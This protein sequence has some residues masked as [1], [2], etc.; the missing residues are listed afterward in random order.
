MPFTNKNTWA[1]AAASKLRE[2]FTN[3]DFHFIDS[4]G[5][6]YEFLD[7]IYF[8]FLDERSKL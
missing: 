8:F 6:N 2:I 7:F 3:T 5:L 4:N 1:D